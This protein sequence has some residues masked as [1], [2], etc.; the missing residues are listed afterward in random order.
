MCRPRAHCYPRSVSNV[1]RREFLRGAG[2]AT[3]LVPAAPL[4]KAC[5]N[6]DDALAPDAGAAPD[7]VEPD[8]VPL[9]DWASGGTDLI[10]VDVPDDDIFGNNDDCRLALIDA[11][12]LGPCY[13]EDVTAE[14]IST[15][16]TGLPMQLC[17]QFVNEDCE[18]LEGY[19]VEVW[20]CDKK[21]LYSGDTSESA[22]AEGFANAFCTSGDADAGQSTWFRGM[23]V[24]NA[25]GRVNFS[26]C[27]PGWY[28]GR[29][30]LFHFRVT[31]ADGTEAIISQ[32]CFTDELAL[33]ICTT[34]PLYVERGEQDTPFAQDSV[35]PGGGPAMFLL[36]SERSSDDTLLAWKRIRIQEPA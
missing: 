18:P 11:T 14:D 35:F 12:T 9:G 25:R 36:E 22:N 17:L 20:H 3:I 29:T 21:G 7:A 13:F 33:E 8:A 30:M 26:R 28:P 2:A 5:G 10:V 32:L 34:H 15:G 23:L 31:S 24:T 4:L 1:K 27:F 16:E 6:S 19:R